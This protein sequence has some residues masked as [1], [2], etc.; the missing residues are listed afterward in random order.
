MLAS[1]NGVDSVGWT[2]LMVACVGGFAD[3]A[4]ALLTDERVD[5]NASFDAAGGTPFIGAANN[6]RVSVLR[7]LLADERVD[8]SRVDRD[9][10]GA[11]ARAATNGC[12]ETVALLLR[13]RL[14]DDDG[15]GN[16]VDPNGA[17]HCGNT[18]LHLSAES[19]HDSVIR[20]LLADA[21]V[22]PNSSND[23]EN[24]ALHLSVGRSHRRAV[25]ALLAH[26]GERLDPNVPNRHNNTP[27]A[28]AAARCGWNHPDP[29]AVL[30][31]LLTDPR[32][33]RVRPPEHEAGARAA[34]DGALAVVERRRPRRARFRGLVRAAVAFRRAHRRAALLLSLARAGLSEDP[35]RAV[36]AFL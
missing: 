14:A 29:H 5:R 7:L 11:L 30:E 28:L 21:R 18:A 1:P 27:L 34:Y 8:R 22:D 20:V 24:S 15:S 4:A 25:A 33:A 12:C 32:T 2:A 6:G 36:A 10:D 19:G 16:G 3:V 13:R 31:L 35:S 26:S 9:G 23:W 17:N